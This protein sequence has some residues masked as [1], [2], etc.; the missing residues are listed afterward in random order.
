LPLIDKMPKWLSDPPPDHVFEISEHA[1]TGVSPRSPDRQNRERLKERGLTASP[2]LPNILRPQLY[3]DALA[4]VAM[5]N[6]SRRLTAALVIPDYAVRMAILDFEEFPVREEERIS[7][8]RFRLRKTV[9]FHIEEARV[10]YSIQDSRPG[11]VE[12]LAV[13]IASPILR[14]YESIFVEAGHRVGLVVP[15]LIAALP[16]CET[17]H[18]GITLLAKSTGSTLS[19][20]LIEQGRVRLV[21]CLDLSTEE[22]ADAGDAARNVFPVLQQTLA[23]AEDQLEQKVNRALLCGFGVDTGAVGEQMENE[24]GIPYTPVSSRF[25]PAHAENAGL[26]GLLEQFAA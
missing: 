26:L 8:L 1:L 7:L 17:E 19:M 2:S 14:E 25:G 3:R 20:G 11:H 12:I 10:A 23:F 24:F 21:R 5:A 16:F 22:N 6:G 15:S 18:E 13:A 4:R 9:P